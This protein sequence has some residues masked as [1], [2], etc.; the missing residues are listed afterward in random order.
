MQARIVGL[1][2]AVTQGDA[3]ADFYSRVFGASFSKR[4]VGSFELYQ[5]TLGQMN[6]LLCPRELA[7]IEADQN[8]HQLTFAI[9]DVAKT[10]AVALSAGGSSIEPPNT[11]PDGRTTASV[12]DPDGNSI[13]LVQQRAS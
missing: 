11:G 3:M 4:L 8:R 6:I 1:T 9:D 13:E 12:R 7:G 10:Y 2:I 5:G